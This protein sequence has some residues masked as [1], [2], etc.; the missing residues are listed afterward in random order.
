MT[1]Q[2]ERRKVLLEAPKAGAIV[3]EVV[4]SGTAP[5][6]HSGAVCVCVRCIAFGFGK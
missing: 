1:K 3:V 6:V 5:A 2:F 4:E